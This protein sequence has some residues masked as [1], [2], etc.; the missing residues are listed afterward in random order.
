M[1]EPEEILK[2]VQA[3]DV[4]IRDLRERQKTAAAAAG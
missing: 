1:P 4:W 3:L 2:D